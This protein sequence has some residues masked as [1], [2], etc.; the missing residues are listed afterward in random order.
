[1]AMTLDDDIEAALAVACEELEMTREE[2]IRGL[3][4]RRA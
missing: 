2:M 3:G 1:M 4:F